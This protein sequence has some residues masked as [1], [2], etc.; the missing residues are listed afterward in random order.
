MDVNE[1]A[2]DVCP[3]CGGAGVFEYEGEWNVQVACS[4]CSGHTVYVEYD[5][6]QEKECA[7]KQV[8]MLWNI[9]KVIKF[10]AGD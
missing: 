3:L 9:G 8:A 2:L 10:G 4:D 5:T 7:V 1:P 6:E